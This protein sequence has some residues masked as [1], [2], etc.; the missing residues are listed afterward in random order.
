MTSSEA[1]AE[2]AGELY[3]LPA[4]EFTAARDARVKQLR[5]DGDKALAA[6]V[7][8]LRKPTVA[9][10][11]VNLLVRRRED[12]V[13]EVLAIGESLRE[14]QAGLE[15]AALRELSRQRRQVVA[16][17]VATTRQLTADEGVRLTEPAADQVAATLQA[18]LA[19]P[20]AA[21]L[22]LAGCLAQPLSSTGMASFGGA[23]VLRP[24][25]DPAP[26]AT[27][28]ELPARV[29]P[30]VRRRAEQAV[31]HAEAMVERAR[32]GHREATERHR[33]AQAEL[34][35]LES[36]LEELRREVAAAES[37]AETGAGEVEEAEDEA[38]E[39]A[40]LVEAA[41]AQLEEAREAL[42]E[43]GD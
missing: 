20:E 39:T 41:Q 22:V 18:A 15:G 2:V 31:R 24:V 32:A 3:A 30:G 21:A 7:K 25:P 16:A 42:E 26:S 27:V 5:S 9:A 43:L 34:L 23:G 1:L 28:T 40:E 35:R 14:A 11:A 10:W 12:L 19:E 17:V 38:A 6:E 13:R 37:A 4:D 29:D 33:A 36:R 8:A